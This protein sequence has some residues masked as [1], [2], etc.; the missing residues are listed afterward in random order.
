MLFG[1]IHLSYKPGTSLRDHLAC[2]KN[3]YVDL[4]ETIKGQPPEL[5]FLEVSQGMAAVLFLKSVR[6]NTLLLSLV[7]SSY[8][9]TPFTLM[10]VSNCLMLE[11]SRRKSHDSDSTYLTHVP[12]SGFR[13][14]SEACWQPDAS[15]ATKS[16]PGPTLPRPVAPTR[17]VPAKGN[18]DIQNKV[19]LLAEELRKLQSQLSLNT[20][21]EENNSPDEEMANVIS[22][23]E[24]DPEVAGFLVQEDGLY[25]TSGATNSRLELIYDSGASRSTICNYSLLLDPTPIS[26]SLNTHGGK[27]QITHVGKLDIGG[28]LI[29]PVYYAPCGP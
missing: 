12:R 24:C 10:V 2:F 8:D 18:L 3:L 14:K 13:Q 29:Y 4:V 1:L 22:E 28:T 21:E 19:N 15:Q 7:Q 25:N 27:V 20:V 23:D 9:L 6:H 16:R 17:K 5:R 26:K 11:D